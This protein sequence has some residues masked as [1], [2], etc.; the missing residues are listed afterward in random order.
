METSKISLEKE[1]RQASIF[2]MITNKRYNVHYKNRSD[3]LRKEIDDFTK[4]QKK[5]ASVRELKSKIQSGVEAA[6]EDVKE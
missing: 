3:G 2:D 4:V 1:A 5:I 6:P